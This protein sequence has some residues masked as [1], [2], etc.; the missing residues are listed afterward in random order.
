MLARERIGKIIDEGT[1][2]LELSALAA[3][4]KHDGKAKSASVITG[5]GV[6]HG[7]ECMFIANDST[8]NGGAFYPETGKKMLR[9]QDIA[10]ANRL[11][12]LYL[13]DG[14]GANLAAAGDHK[15]VDFVW[16]GRLFRN[17]VVMSG[18]SVPQLGCAFGNCTAGAAY[19]A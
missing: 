14:G 4:D 10:A 2:F 5:I 15:S 3:Y 8:I 16:G 18:K 6:V 11:P 1:E 17:Q 19:T 9:A 12:T 7:R 13:V